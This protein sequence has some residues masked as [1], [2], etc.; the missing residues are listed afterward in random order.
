MVQEMIENGFFLLPQALKTN[1]LAYL[2]STFKISKNKNEK[3][4]TFKHFH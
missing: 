4:K 1:Y 3:A 2:R